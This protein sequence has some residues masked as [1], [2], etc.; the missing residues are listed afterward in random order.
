MTKECTI[1]K[2]TFSKHKKESA[3]QWSKRK[4]CGYWCSG[5][6][7]ASLLRGKPSPML[8][9]KHTEEAKEKTRIA[10][11]GSKSFLW[12]GGI[13]SDRKTYYKLKGIER[14]ALQLNAEG[15][16]THE[17]WQTIKQRFGC[18]CAHCDKPEQ[19]VKLTIDHVIPLTKGGTN[20]A[21]NLQPLCQPC[22]S[23]KGNRI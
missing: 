20:W 2:T 14:R 6:N 15:S 11:L 19:L 16:F 8:G 23:R 21:S 12:K 4:F 7:N 13:T 22:N 10:H 3:L 18:K 9:K 17:E 5:T 1:C